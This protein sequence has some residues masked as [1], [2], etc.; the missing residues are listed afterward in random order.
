MRKNRKFLTKDATDGGKFWEKSIWQLPSRDQLKVLSDRLVTTFLEATT[1]M[2]MALWHDLH[3]LQSF[4]SD[5]SEPKF[6]MC[7]F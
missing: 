4:S 3:V 1:T 2:L 6:E 5:G 7:S